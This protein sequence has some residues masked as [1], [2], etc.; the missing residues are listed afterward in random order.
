MGTAQARDLAERFLNM[1]SDFQVF[2]DADDEML[3]GEG[4]DG[5]TNMLNSEARK[6]K[7]EELT[8]E[9]DPSYYERV[10]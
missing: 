7:K 4:A 1:K 9:I 3:D 6:L 10:T 2:L 5:D 8:F